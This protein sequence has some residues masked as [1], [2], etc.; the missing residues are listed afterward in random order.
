MSINLNAT[1]RDTQGKGAS[2]RLRKANQVPAIVYGGTKKA[3]N[4][5]LDFFEISHL[6]DFSD[7]IYS[8]ILELSVDG[9]KA[10]KVI[11]KDMQRHPAQNT[12]THLDFQRVSAKTAIT[13][14][15]PI[16]LVGAKN[17]PD[18]RLGAIINKFIDMVEIKCLPKD[19]PNSIELDITNLKIGDSV[20]LSG[21]EIAKG[22]I[23]TA[24]NH[25]DDSHDQTVVSLSAP[26]LKKE[27]VDGGSD[28]DGSDSA[29]EETAEEE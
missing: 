1:T 12:V 28:S 21:L 16:V 24:L 4:L 7:D 22:V 27:K 2:R 5:A 14:A 17:N 3:Q 9:K 29:S 19:L 25:N 18:I 10:E 26:K 13:T 20:R 15:V 23:I 11:L 6:L 8:S